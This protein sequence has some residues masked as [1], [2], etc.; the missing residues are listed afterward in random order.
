MSQQFRYNQL[1]W[2]SVEFTSSKPSIYLFQLYAVCSSLISV[3]TTCY[4]ISSN[5]NK[6]IDLSV[7]S[8]AL[9]ARLEQCETAMWSFRLYLSSNVEL[10]AGTRIAPAPLENSLRKWPRNFLG[11]WMECKLAF[12]SLSLRAWM[13]IVVLRTLPGR[14]M[15]SR[16]CGHWKDIRGSFFRMRL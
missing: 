1:F 14:F 10:V 6:S 3:K 15:T 2:N 8:I 16:M 13:Q 11:V 9:L 7:I 4:I 5:F 12:S